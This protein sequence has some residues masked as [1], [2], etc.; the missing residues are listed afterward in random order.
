MSGLVPP[1]PLTYTGQIAVPSINRTFPPTTSF[2]DFN[3]PTIWTDTLN[4]NSYILVSKSL[5]VANWILIGGEPGVL[6]TITTPDSTVVVPMA[7]NIDFLNG[8]GMHITGSGSDIT[9]TP[10]TYT[11][12][13]GTGLTGGGASNL[14]SAVTVSLSSPVSVAH[15]GTGDT[16]LTNHSV[17]LGQGTSAVSFAGPNASSNAI[18]MAQGSSSD[19]AFTTSGT[20]YVTAISFNAGTDTLSTY[21]TTTYTPVLSFG[22]ASTGITYSAQDG[23]YTQIG[24]VVYCSVHIQLSSKG[25]STGLAAITL[26]VATSAGPLACFNA[27]LFSGITLDIPYQ[28]IG[29]YAQSGFLNLFESGTGLSFSGLTDSMF[30]NTTD[31]YVTWFYFAA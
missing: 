1:G 14:D 7:G 23:K 20:P 16:T 22:G 18:F 15:G 24:N 25:S 27:N 3:V 28:T 11:V 5:G 31:L 12:T 9:F 26:P 2:N 29:G 17:L 10:G 19:P 6:D 8:T 21:H 13:A 4:K 30:S